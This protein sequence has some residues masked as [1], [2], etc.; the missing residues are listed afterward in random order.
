MEAHN[1]GVINFQPQSRPVR[2]VSEDPDRTA[3]A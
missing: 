1:K 3:K 2:V